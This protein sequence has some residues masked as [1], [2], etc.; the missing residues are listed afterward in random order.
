M[1]LTVSEWSTEGSMAA[2]A[3]EGGDEV[4]RSARSSAEGEAMGMKS[5]KHLVRRGISGFEC[6]KLGAW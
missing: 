3:V 5:Q 2:R 4:G 6:K 1:L